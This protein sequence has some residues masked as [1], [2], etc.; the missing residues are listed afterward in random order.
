MTDFFRFSH[1]APGQYPILFA[2]WTTSMRSLAD[3]RLPDLFLV[4]DV[5]DRSVWRFWLSAR[6]HALAQVPGLRT[7]GA[8]NVGVATQEQRIFHR[9]SVCRVDTGEGIDPLREDSDWQPA[10]VRRIPEWTPSGDGNWP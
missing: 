7:L 3:G 5:C 6:R 2:E 8:G 1:A 9:S 4:F 10:Q